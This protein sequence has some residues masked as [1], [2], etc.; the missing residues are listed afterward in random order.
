MVRTI[1]G[2]IKSEAGDWPSGVQVLFEIRRSEGDSN[3]RRVV[4]DKDG[5]FKLGPVK[6]GTFCF[7]A[8]ATGWQSV[9]GTIIIN[10]E[11][12]PKSRITFQMSLGV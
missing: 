11:A 10:P 7:K 9:T 1:D 5:K 8:T 6:K 4:T 2:V 12:D 3:I